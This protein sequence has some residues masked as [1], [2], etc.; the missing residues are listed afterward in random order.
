MERSVR[1]PAPHPLR[2]PRH[3]G[4]AGCAASPIP[5]CRWRD[6]ARPAE[7]AGTAAGP[8]PVAVAPLPSTRTAEPFERLRD[9]SDA[10]SRPHGSRPKVFLAN[11][12]SVAAFTARATFAKNFFEAGGI[13]A[14]MNDG[15]TD[16][17]SLRQLI[18]KAKPS[19]HASARLMKYTKLMPLRQQGPCVKPDRNLFS[20]L[21]APEKMNKSLSGQASPLSSLPG[22]TPSRS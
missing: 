3:R 13:E 20:W 12:G 22:A 6:E 2:Q 4:E 16:Q 5:R 9:I 1:R 14:V 19:F 17:D 15:L 10:L 7:L 8:S 11:L 21:A 18:F